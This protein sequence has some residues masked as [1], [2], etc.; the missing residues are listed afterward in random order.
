[1]KFDVFP[2]VFGGFVVGYLVCLLSF[3]Q[4]IFFHHRA[5][6]RKAMEE[7]IPLDSKCPACGHRGCELIFNEP[8]EISNGDDKGTTRT[9]EA[10]VGRK[11]NTCGAIAYEKTVLEPEKWIAK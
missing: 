1:M 10:R 5:A 3:H 11:C 9:E 2:V 4:E 6:A 8:R 7:G